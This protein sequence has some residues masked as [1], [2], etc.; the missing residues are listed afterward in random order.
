MNLPEVPTQ[1]SDHLGFDDTFYCNRK[2]EQSFNQQA[3][4]LV[5]V[6]DITC[7]RVS[8]FRCYLCVIMDMYSHKI[9]AWDLATKPNADLVIKVFRKAY[10]RRGEPQG[11]I[12]YSNRGTQYTSIA[13]QQLL[14]SFNVVHSFSKKG[15]PFDHAVEEC[16]FKHLKQEEI[17]RHDYKT[18]E[19]FHSSLFEY[20]DVFYN[21][22]RPGSSFDHLTPNQ[23]ETKYFEQFY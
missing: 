10:A 8:D 20:I 23:M 16:F 22:K 2:Q 18:I 15:Y 12:F 21:A 9:I 19:Q 14:N 7:I 11:L 1:K 17:D 5:W 13:F 3:P 6:S 4:N